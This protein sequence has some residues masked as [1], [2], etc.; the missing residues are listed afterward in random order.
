MLRPYAISMQT[1]S[2]LFK[3]LLHKIVAD[4]VINNYA[5]RNYPFLKTPV[6]EPGEHFSTRR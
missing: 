1:L 4:D 6:G 3:G 5:I 2:F